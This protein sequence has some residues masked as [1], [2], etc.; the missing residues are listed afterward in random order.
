MGFVLG[1][2][3]GCGVGDI[4]GVEFSIEVSHEEGGGLVL[5]EEGGEVCV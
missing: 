5:I 4:R 2:E 3:G 1:I